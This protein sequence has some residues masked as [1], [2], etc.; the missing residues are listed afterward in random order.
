M[1]AFKPGTSPLP[2]PARRI[3]PPLEI[4][5]QRIK[6]VLPRVAFIGDILLKD[7]NRGGFAF[8]GPIFNG[9]GDRWTMRCDGA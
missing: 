7:A 2:D 9:S 8:L 6:R 1:T 4:L 5:A 3:D